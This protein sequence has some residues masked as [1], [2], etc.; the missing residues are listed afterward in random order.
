[1]P[2]NEALFAKLDELAGQL[3]ELDASLADPAVTADHVKVTEL[4]QKRAALLPVCDLYKAYRAADQEADDLAQMA[5]SESDPELRQMA[6]DELAAAR[7]KAADLLEQLKGELVTS[8]DRAVGSVILELRAGVGGDEAGLFASELLEMYQKYAQQHGWKWNPMDH[9]ASEIGGLKSA[10]VNL[11]GEGVWQRL[12]YEGGTHC[13]KRVPATESQGRV[14]T[15]TATV[16]VLPEP[17]DVEININEDDV[18]IDIT[19]ARGPGGQNVNKVATAVKLLHVP[20]GIEVRMQDTK[21]QHQNR[22]LAWQLLR[23]RL[24]EH[25]RQTVEAERAEARSQMIGSAGRGERVRTYRWKEGIVV[26]HRLGQ[27]FPL[28][29]LM[30]GNL[31]PLTDALIEQDKTQRLAAL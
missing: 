13:V 11:K 3:S 8:D 25:H 5:D 12:G 17:K 9:S 6:Q 15:S 20:T 22:T 21:S 7:S 1:M 23:A 18:K 24:Y 14:H 10:T 31:D 28:T 30:S 16:A 27:S 26:D 2:S 4:S 29:P 19:T